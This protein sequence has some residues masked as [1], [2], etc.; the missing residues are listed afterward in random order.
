[1]DRLIALD[2]GLSKFNPLKTLICYDDFDRGA[3]GWVDLTPNFRFDDFQPLKGASSSI[4]S[5]TH[6]RVCA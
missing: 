2:V 4:T 6:L 5:A 1:M 3:N